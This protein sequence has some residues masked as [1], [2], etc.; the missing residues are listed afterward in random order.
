MGIIARQAVRNTILTYVGI[1]LGF[2]NVV[3]L[4]PKVLDSAEFGLT[5][6]LLSVCIITAQVAQ[7]GAEST[8]VR[9]FGYF[10]DPQ[11]GHRGLLGMLLVFGTAAGLFAMLVLGLF[12]GVLS[13]VF[14]D[15]NA[16]YGRYGLFVLPLVLS[17]IFFVLLRGYS[18][19]L[20]RSVQPVFIREFLLRLLQTLIILVQWAWPMPFGWFMVLYT[21]VF[22]FTT[23]AL[24]YDLRRAGLFT[25][26]WNER[27][28]PRRL[29]NSMA[30][31][32]GYTLLTGLAGIAL[33][34]LDQLMIGALLG[35]GLKYVAYYAVGFYFGS[36]IA[37]PTRAL[38]QVAMPLLADA[39]KRGD[40][41]A[42]ADLYRRSSLVQTMVAGFLL[43]LLW[44]SV[45][46]LFSLLS[47]EYAPASVVALVIGSAY[48]L[49]SMNGLNASLI[50]MSRAYRVEAWSNVALLLLSVLGNLLLI[51]RYGPL[52]AAWTTLLA[53][54]L[55]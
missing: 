5:R 27:R 24:V 11:R 28:L 53:L 52:G 12:H 29:R 40:R 34:N 26:G 2:L 55:V 9:Y 42:I 17:E 15:R 54:V 25:I 20:L 36:V 10:R 4:Y 19:S 30:V 49:N 21:G 35:D 14:S 32:G 47:A 44:A 23:L 45:D 18:R 46:D 43:L 50:G 37:A 41:G 8:V 1:G 48:F 3:L 13:D 22:L 38:Q 31:Y 7:L 39:W 6:L 51:A 16:L 33:G